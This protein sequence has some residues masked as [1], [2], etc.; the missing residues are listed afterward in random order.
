MNQLTVTIPSEYVILTREE[1]KQLLDDVDSRVWVS[2]KELQE[3]T[4]LKRTKLDQILSRYRDELDL[5]NGGPVKF[6]DGGKWNFNKKQTLKW[7]EENH[8]RIWMEDPY[9]GNLRR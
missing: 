9:Y 3:L 1:H 7:L 6:A 8:K 2:F 4:G 5:K